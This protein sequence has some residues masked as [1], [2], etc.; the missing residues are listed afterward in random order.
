M[1][2]FTPETIH[3]YDSFGRAMIAQLVKNGEELLEDIPPGEQRSVELNL[4]A[5]ITFKRKPKPDP[6]PPPPP[7]PPEPCCVVLKYPD[8]TIVFGGSCCG[9]PFPA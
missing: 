3:T 8:G 9:G 2:L 6:E 5:L 1:S 7:P 4:T